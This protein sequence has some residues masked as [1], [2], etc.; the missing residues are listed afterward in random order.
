[1]RGAVLRIELMR[2]LA[3]RRRFA[4]Q[5]GAVDG[6]QYGFAKVLLQ[7]LH[8]LF[9]FRGDLVI[10]GGQDAEQFPLPTFFR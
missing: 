10:E 6:I 2:D 9:G 5:G 7:F 3:F 8:R 4:Q 1:M